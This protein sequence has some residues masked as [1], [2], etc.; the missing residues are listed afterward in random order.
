MDSVNCVDPTDIG[1]VVTGCV[2]TQHDL[3]SREGFPLRH[4][5]A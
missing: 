3:V 2:D 1:N 4:P 5:L